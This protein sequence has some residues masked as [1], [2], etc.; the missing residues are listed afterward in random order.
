MRTAFVT[1]ITGQDGSYLAEQLLDRGYRVVGMMLGTER[2]NLGAAHHLS[3]SIELVDGDLRNA[4]SLA[5]AI[6]TTQ[7][8]EVYSLAALSFVQTSWDDPALVGDVTGL[9]PMRL[10]EAVRRHAPRAR[11]C[12]ASSS[13]IFGTP[14]GRLKRS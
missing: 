1:G 12:Q 13:E 3:G 6:E 8:D 14:I 4:T 10:L 11:F 7:P 9:G 2:G 5:V